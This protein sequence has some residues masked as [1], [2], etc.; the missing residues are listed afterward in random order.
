MKVEGTTSVREERA[1]L[2]VL[3]DYYE[4]INAF[5]I[6]VNKRLAAAKILGI[7]LFDS[8]ES[9]DALRAELAHV[10]ELGERAGVDNTVAT[11]NADAVL[12]A[13]CEDVVRRRFY[14]QT[15]KGRLAHATKT[16]PEPFSLK[17]LEERYQHRNY[18]MQRKSEGLGL[19]PKFSLWR[20]SEDF[21][22]TF[23][24]DLARYV[25]YSRASRGE[26]SSLPHSR[27]PRGKHPSPLSRE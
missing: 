17:E 2:E 14:A 16:E 21:T 11:L 5:V 8:R 26:R 27:A 13:L 7:S 24:D 19:G 22:G 3:D 9:V 6:V 20:K 10:A 12:S 15:A 1:T 23:Y 18:K 4:G 25:P